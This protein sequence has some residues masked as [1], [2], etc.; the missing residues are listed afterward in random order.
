[1][2][3]EVSKTLSNIKSFGRKYSNYNPSKQSWANYIKGKKQN[4]INRGRWGMAKIFPSRRKNRS[5]RKSRKT[6]KSRK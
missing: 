2:R 6:R 5:S 3:N 1:M 4:V